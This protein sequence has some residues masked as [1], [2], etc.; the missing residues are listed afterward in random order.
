MRLVL[1]VISVI[2]HHRLTQFPHSFI[3]KYRVILTPTLSTVDI[4][5]HPE[6]RVTLTPTLSTGDI[7]THPEYRVTLT[8]TLSTE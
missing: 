1:W 2:E 6:Y 8:L 4:D 7:D 5:T 3:A